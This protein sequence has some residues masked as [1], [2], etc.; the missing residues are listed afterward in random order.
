MRWTGIVIV[1][2]L[3]L[4]LLAHALRVDSEEEHNRSPREMFGAFLEKWKGHEG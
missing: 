3:G 4:G 2:L 1:T